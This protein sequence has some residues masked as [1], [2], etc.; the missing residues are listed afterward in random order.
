MSDQPDKKPSVV[1]RIINTPLDEVIPWENCELPSKGVYYG[2]KLPGG[3]LKVRAM[4]LYADKVL[5]TQRLAQTGQAV[6]WLLNKCV[7]FPDGFNQDELLLGD[8]TFL[9][10]YLRGITH[11]NIYEFVFKCPHEDCAADSTQSYDMNLLY[12]TVKPPN[13]DIGLEPFKI[14]LPYM[15][16]TFGEDVSVGIR[17]LRGR[18]GTAML[19]SKKLEKRG[20]LKRDVVDDTIERNLNLIIME[21]NG[22]K[23]R[24]TISKIVARLHATDTATIRQFLNENAPGISAT[25]EIECPDCSRTVKVEMPITE[26]FFRPAKQ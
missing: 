10:Y 7:Q 21:V 9:L 12:Q 11:G 6:Q 5:A 14:G 17:F 1:D 18:D 24:S 8:R 25:I 19:N 13:P 2:D 4:G 20:G 3:I 22:N 15:T 16:K 23:D 26:S